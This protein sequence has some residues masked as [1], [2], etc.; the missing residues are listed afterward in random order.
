[1]KLIDS[2][3][4]KISKVAVKNLSNQITEGKGNLFLVGFSQLEPLC[5]NK[6]ARPIV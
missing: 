4:T 1:M 6:P 2:P 3:E 5:G